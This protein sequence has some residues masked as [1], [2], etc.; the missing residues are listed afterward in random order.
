MTC[1]VLDQVPAPEIVDQVPFS[2]LVDQVY[3]VVS[4]S[5]SPTLTEGQPAVGAVI[6]ADPDAYLE[7]SRSGQA[8]AGPYTTGARLGSS[9]LTTDQDRSM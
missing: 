2:E 6:S 1:Q 3:W 8:I 7:T 4:F 9:F 5:A